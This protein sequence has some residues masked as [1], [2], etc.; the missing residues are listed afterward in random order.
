[1]LPST[2]NRIRKGKMNLLW[3]YTAMSEEGK[4]MIFM[5]EQTFLPLRRSG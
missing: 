5:V 3:R 1:M 4:E 2:L